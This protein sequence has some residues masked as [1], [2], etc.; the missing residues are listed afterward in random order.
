[1]DGQS[2]TI[3]HNQP[4]A[5]ES[6]KD[7]VDALLKAGDAWSGIEA[8]TDEEQ[9]TR[10]TDLADRVKAEIKA[11]DTARLNATK[12]LRDKTKELNDNY[13]GLV[14]ALEKVKG[15]ISKLQ[16]NYLREQERKHREEIKRQEEEALR[17]L[18]EAEDSRRA[19]EQSANAV[20]ASIDAEQAQKDADDAVKAANKLSKSTV[21]TKGNYGAR[22][23]ALRTVWHAEITDYDKAF[24]HFRDHHQV[25]DLIQ[26]LADQAARSAEKKPIPGVAFK[27]EQKAA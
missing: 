21:G 13:N 8:L 19:A 16:T 24:D 9:A 14:G 4:D 5:F 27:S 10:A 20:T 23:T 1:M 17:K 15:V 26:S 2:P 7:R 11:I 6:L 25:R 3:G 22:A 18:Q 12:P